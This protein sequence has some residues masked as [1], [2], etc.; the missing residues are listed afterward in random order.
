[1]DIFEHAGIYRGYDRGALLYRGYDS[2]LLQGSIWVLR[3]RGRR[4]AVGA[5]RHPSPVSATVVLT[6]QGGRAGASGREEIGG[7]GA[8]LIILA[9]CSQ[10]EKRDRIA[11]YGINTA[12]CIIQRRACSPRFLAATVKRPLANVGCGVRMAMIAGYHPYAFVVVM[13][14]CGAARATV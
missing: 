13:R 1:M 14:R 6:P 9:K 3:R 12:P 5:C 2:Q 11:L 10:S 8:G 4:L 7:G